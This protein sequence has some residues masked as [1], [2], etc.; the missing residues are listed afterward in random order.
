ME[1]INIIASVLTIITAILFFL[2]RYKDKTSH[3]FKMYIGGFLCVI[4][5]I[6]NVH[7]IYTNYQLTTMRSAIEEYQRKWPSGVDFMSNGELKGAILQ[8]AM[9]LEYYKDHC[10][11]TYKH[12]TEFIYNGHDP[13]I[14]DTFWNERDKLK[15]CYEAIKVIVSSTNLK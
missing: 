11:E 3:K 9:I 14:D 12:V 1:N 2:D 4:A 13:R 5:L 8:G 10:P 6:Y 7:I 15:D